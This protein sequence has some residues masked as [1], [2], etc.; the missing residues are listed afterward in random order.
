MKQSEDEVRADQVTEEVSVLPGLV[1]YCRARHNAPH[2]VRDAAHEAFHALTVG[3]R[4]WDRE[5]VHAK[6]LRK[7]NRAEL[8]VH[9]MQARA[10][11]QL[12]CEALSEP[13]KSLDE[14]V[15]VSILEAIKYHMPYADHGVSLDIARTYLERR[16]TKRWALRIARLGSAHPEES[17]RAP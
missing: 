4:N 13:T 10:V 5:K 6:L 11:E 2:D 17:E 7:F 14:W 1:A 15:G 16:D 12:V 9:E 3:A 8:W